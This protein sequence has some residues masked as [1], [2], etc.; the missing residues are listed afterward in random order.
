MSH[1]QKNLQQY[2][3]EKTTG[4]WWERLKATA[5][6]FIKVEKIDGPISEASPSLPEHQD[7][8]E[9]LTEIDQALTQQLTARSS[10][11]SALSGDAL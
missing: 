9:A 8:E 4:S 7:V 5:G 2:P 1:L 3:L 10:P 6:S 11:L